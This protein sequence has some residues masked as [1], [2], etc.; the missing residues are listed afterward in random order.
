MKSNLG[1]RNAGLVAFLILGVVTTSALAATV[2]DQSGTA[3][4]GPQNGLMVYVERKGAKMRILRQ[5]PSTTTASPVTTPP[6]T[7]SGQQPPVSSS[8]STVSSATTVTPAPL[9]T[10]AEVNVSLAELRE[11]DA[12]GN[13]IKRNDSSFR[14][15]TDM[16]F[17]ITHLPDS[18][19]IPNSKIRSTALEAD[20]VAF[21]PSSGNV[22]ID[23]CVA[24]D[25]GTVTLGDET[26]ALI[27]GQLK[28]NL[29][30]K[31]WPW[32]DGA[33]AGSQPAKFLEADFVVQVASGRIVSDASHDRSHGYPKRFS[34]G[35]DAWADF[36]RKVVKSKDRP[37][38][39]G[40]R[41]RP[42][43]DWATFFV[44]VGA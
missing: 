42:S 44:G 34:L 18:H 28:V 17:S 5:L 1:R 31:R 40:G 19:V 26:M 41:G 9:Q 43:P 33:C 2:G 25:N 8:T 15:F 12:N 7:T 10:T 6:T 32:C 39:G 24:K 22:S 16:N 29:E 36:S 30:V 11:L 3:S 13:R 27:Q 37:S 38:H 4:L 14:S 35:K 23:A 20:S 21:P